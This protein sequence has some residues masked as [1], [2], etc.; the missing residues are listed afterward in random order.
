MYKSQE[1]IGARGALV[2]GPPWILGVRGAPRSAPENTA[3]SF[4]L[5]IALGLDGV[6]Y[7]LRGAASGELVLL[8]DESLDRTTDAQGLLATRTLREISELDAGGW[9]GRRFLGER[10][11]FLGEALE[12]P[13]REGDA[14]PQHLIELREP[15][16]VDDVVRALKSR[17]QPLAVRVASSRRDVCRSIEALGVPAMLFVD[18]AGEDER[19]FVR[20]HSIS[21][22]ATA[23]GG[24]RGVDPSNE[25]SAERWSIDVDR[26][27]DLLEACR[28]PLAGFSTTEPE[29]ALA[30]RALVHLTPH[31]DGAYPLETEPL[32][33]DVDA[34][35]GSRAA[36]WGDWSRLVR[37]R[38][39]FGFRVKVICELRVRRGVFEADGLPV[40][41]ALK[42]GESCEVPLHLRGGSWSPGGDPSFVAHFVWT[43][44]PGR[45]GEGLTLDLPLDRLRTQR[46]GENVE[47]LTM[48]AER[49]GDPAASITARRRGA[50]LL[51]ALEN[52]GGLAQA[53]LVAHL[54]G[55]T[56]RG[57]KGLRLRLPRDFGS[58]AA[59]V[60]FNAA[61]VGRESG[62][63]R[64][65]RWAGG[66]PSVLE[67]GEPGRLLPRARA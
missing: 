54:D 46:V 3:A 36:W 8:A 10:L 7:E 33:V 18:R 14:L 47:R 1:G 37:V 26:P 11:L 28:L 61:I 64:V 12:L 25:W 50:D 27:D 13:G 42:P 67:S 20:D 55:A 48:L 59:G 16:L 2:P 31:D 39:P 53:H 52:P 43:R 66:L 38:N 22:I 32:F 49:P 56:I 34:R 6:H 21:A 58:R 44:G 30:V 41:F 4:A 65:R 40:Q 57:G 45:P 51:L 35:R 24:W 60:R 5:A 19:N 63:T 29:R 15:R 9:F 62:A 23:P 17:E